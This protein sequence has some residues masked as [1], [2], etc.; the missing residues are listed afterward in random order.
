MCRLASWIDGMGLRMSVEVGSVE[1]AVGI[2]A[3][4]DRMR[5]LHFVVLKK[6]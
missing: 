4:V 2:V 6:V 1:V 3:A 5:L